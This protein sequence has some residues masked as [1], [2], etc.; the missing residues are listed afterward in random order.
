MIDK[1]GNQEK[2]KWGRI[3]GVIALAI[4]MLASLV[5]C[6]GMADNQQNENDTTTAEAQ[7]DNGNNMNDAVWQTIPEKDEFGDEIEGGTDTIATSLTGSFDNSTT[8]DGELSLLV[9]VGQIKDIKK[10][11]MIFKLYEQGEY[12]VMPES[13]ATAVL[14]TKIDD[15]ITEYPL[16]IGKDNSLVLGGKDNSYCEEFLMDLM[17][18]EEGIRCIIETESSVMTR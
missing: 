2:T 11:F 10:Y 7:K 14:K 18:N 9:G 5:C 12:L 13:S 4:F 8:Q 16:I 1:N 15:N 6:S 3:I 17:D